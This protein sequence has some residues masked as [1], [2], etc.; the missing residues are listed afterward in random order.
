MNMLEHFPP[1]GQTDS[2]LRIQFSCALGDIRLGLDWLVGRLSEHGFGADGQQQCKQVVAEILNNVA[3]HAYAGCP[4]GAIEMDLAFHQSSACVTIRDFGLPMP[5]ERLPEGR[6]PALDVR[7]EDLP[8]GGFG[9]FIIRQLS[10]DLSYVREPGRNVLRVC[11]ADFGGHSG[12]APT[13]DALRAFE[14]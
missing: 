11:L 8:E 12:A 7:A 4:A 6:P 3:E 10:T 1:A 13:T 9:W 14:R 5:G 2:D